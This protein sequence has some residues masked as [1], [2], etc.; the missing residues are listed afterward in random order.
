[1]TIRHDFE[2]F[3]NKNPH[4]YAQLVKMAREW[5]RATDTKLGIKTLYERL[6]WEYGL[7]GK[8]KHG[9]KLNNNY[10]PYYARLI[11]DENPDLQGMFDLRRLNDE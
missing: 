2:I 5:R 4:V 1:M 7:T 9:F 3:H 11:M 8:D 6:R 10:A